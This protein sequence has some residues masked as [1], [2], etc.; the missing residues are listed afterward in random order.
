MGKRNKGAIAAI[1]I[2]GV[3]M[4]LLFGG[5]F[6][7]LRKTNDIY[8]DES[9]LPLEND[10]D[11]DDALEQEV[12]EPDP[13][14]VKTYQS[15]QITSEDSFNKNDNLTYAYSLDD[16]LI[17]PTS[18]SNTGSPSSVSARRHRSRPQWDDALPMRIR[19]DV[20]APPGKLGIII[21]TSSQG[22]I[23][24]IVKPGSALEGLVFDG[25]LIIAVDDEDTSDWS[26]HYLTKLMAQ[27]S[28]YERKITVLS[29]EQ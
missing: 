15:A 10:Y 19:R 20:V 24:H 12:F 1:V 25:D 16:G 18:L 27:K 4:L 17:S 6:H 8:N 21:D 5:L 9:Q 29:M 28:K 13:A 3:A 23:I 2:G 14:Y 26:A 7:Q 11:D 22:P